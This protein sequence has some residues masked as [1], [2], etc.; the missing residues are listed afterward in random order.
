MNNKVKR[1]YPAAWQRYTDDIVGL[2]RT[3]RGLYD[4]FDYY[5]IVVT[6]NYSP[7]ESHQW[8]YEVRA[9]GRIIIESY[10]YDSRQE[11]EDAGFETAFEELN[12]IILQGNA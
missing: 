10:R 1:L 9:T 6:V 4:F 8:G 11:A 12:K 3:K 7:D 5:C 2:L